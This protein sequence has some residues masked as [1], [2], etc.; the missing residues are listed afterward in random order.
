MESAALL[1]ESGAHVE[2]ICRGDVNWLGTET[3]ATKGKGPLRA[4]IGGMRAP[5]GVGPFPLDWLAELPGMLRLCPTALRSLFSKR[6]LRP[7]AAGWLMG[8]MSGVNVNAGRAVTSAKVEQ[9]ALTLKLHD[10]TR[11]VVDHALL[12][13]G[14]K[15]D[16]SKP[17]ILAPS[18]VERVQ[19]QPGTGCPILSAHY[20]SSIPGLHFAGSS[21]VPSYGPMMRF[22]S[23]VSYAAHSITKGALARTAQ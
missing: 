9:G 23:G 11:A 2:V 4:L 1:A 6:C 7:A 12:A 13:T 18:L 10:G 17:G 8:R 19:L 3:H 20:E 14:Y 15:L 21:A 22:V 5:G 16:I